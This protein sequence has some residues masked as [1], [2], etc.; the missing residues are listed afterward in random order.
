M[1][2][3]CAAAA[4]VRVRLLP[5][6]PPPLCHRSRRRRHCHRHRCRV[7][8]FHCD[9]EGA[10]LNY[11]R[12]VLEGR[13]IAH[14]LRALL[15]FATAILCRPIFWVHAREKWAGRQKLLCRCHARA[16]A[17]CRCTRNYMTAREPRARARVK[18]ERRAVVRCS[19]V[20]YLLS[21]WLALVAA[22]HENPAVF[23]QYGGDVLLGTMCLTGMASAW[24]VVLLACS[25]PCPEFASVIVRALL[26]LST[27]MAAV[28]CLHVRVLV[29]AVRGGAAIPVLALYGL[30]ALHGWAVM[31]A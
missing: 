21:L 24:A 23:L 25:A 12:F 16:R 1:Q 8:G 26:A 14:R 6:L 11:E 28:M 27:F 31:E 9:H 10:F 22:C 15:F 18:M 20:V 4:V 30:N 17:R 29:L 7:R 19:A 2:P 3:V 5:Q 13:T